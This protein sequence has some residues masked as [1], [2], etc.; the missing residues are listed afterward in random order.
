MNS[1]RKIFYDTEFIERP[2]TID[3]ISI[4]MVD[5]Q[6]NEYYAISRDFDERYASPWVK[7]NVLPLLPTR[8]KPVWKSREEITDG[9]LNFLS[10]SKDFDIELWGYYA[11]YDHVA[12]CWL[13]GKMIDLPDGVPKYTRDLKQLVDE[14]KTKQLPL[15]KNEHNAL[16]DA[17]WNKDLYLHIKYEE[18]INSVKGKYATK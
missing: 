18:H 5:L 8:D 2:C 16:E 10:P 14:R 11:D 7:K 3:L 17:R 15:Q 4:G 6:G 13:F 12:L 1:T 9:V